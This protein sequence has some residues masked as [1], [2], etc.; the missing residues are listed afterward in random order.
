MYPKIPSQSSSFFLS[1]IFFN[2]TNS[3][4]IIA[5]FNSKSSHYFFKSKVNDQSSFNFVNLSSRVAKNDLF[6]SYFYPIF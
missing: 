3:S 4:F 1:P 2:S 5:I 6:S